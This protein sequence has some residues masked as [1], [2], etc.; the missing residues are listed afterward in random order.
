MICFELFTSSHLSKKNRCEKIERTRKS[1][2]QGIGWIRQRGEDKVNS[3]QM[4][5]DPTSCKY[6]SSCSLWSI[7]VITHSSFSRSLLSFSP[8]FLFSLS[9]SCT[10]ALPSSSSQSRLQCV[11]RDMQGTSLS[12]VSL[13]TYALIKEKRPKYNECPASLLDND[14]LLDVYKSKWGKYLRVLAPHSSHPFKWRR[15][16]RRNLI[17]DNETIRRWLN[18]VLPS[19]RICTICIIKNIQK[20]KELIIIVG[21]K[22][23]QKIRLPVCFFQ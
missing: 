9:R 3:R 21:S 6:M 8:L 14:Q 18:K 20:G 12:D 7:E 16:R 10:R 2:Q 4:D 15:R 13:L 11:I 17:E 23:Q 19:D 22:N 5:I 1:V